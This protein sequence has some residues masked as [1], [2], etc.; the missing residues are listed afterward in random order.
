MPN[1][2]KS[3]TAPRRFANLYGDRIQGVGGSCKLFRGDKTGDFFAFLCVLVG[4]FF[5]VGSPMNPRRAGVNSRLRFASRGGRAG[6]FGGARRGKSRH[7][8]NS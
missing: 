3:A 2:L 4:C 6:D 8:K 1:R 7:E 5:G